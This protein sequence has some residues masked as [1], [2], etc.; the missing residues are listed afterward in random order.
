MCIR[1]RRLIA[2]L[3]DEIKTFDRRIDKLGAEKYM[4]TQLLRQV[5]GVGPVSYTHLDVYKRQGLALSSAQTL[6]EMNTLN[7]SRNSSQI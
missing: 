2:T 1:D 3:S 7:G 5:V 4:H 6:L